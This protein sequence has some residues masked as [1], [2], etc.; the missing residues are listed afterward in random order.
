MKRCLAIFLLTSL[1]AFADTKKPAAKLKKVPPQPSAAQKNPQENAKEKP[2]EP[3]SAETFEGLKLRSIGPAMISGRIVAL[4]VDPNNRAHYYAGSASGGL[5]KTLNDGIT[6]QPVF[7]HEGSYSIGAVVLDPH[8]PNI[9]WVGTGESNSQRSVAWGDGVYRSD[10]GGKSW[11]NVGLKHSEHIGRIVIDP[12]DTNVVYVA[13]EGPLWSSG[14]DRGLYKTS[15]GGKSWQQVLKIS[16]NTG[17]GDVAMDPDN[18]D[19]LYAAAYQRQRKVWTL[20]DGGPESALYKST[21]AGKTWNKLSSGLP[22]EEMG[23]IGL[24]ISPAD[25][26]TI[27]ATIEA[28]NKAGGIFRSKDGGATWEKRNPFDSTA[29]YYAQVIADPKNVNRIYVMNFNIMDSEDGGKTLTRFPSKSKHVDNHVIWIDPNDTDYVLVGCDGGVYESYDRG[30]N[31][32]YKANLPLAQFYDITA[33]NSVP[34]YYVYGGAQD[35][36][37][38]GG[39]SRTT[40]ASGIIN[41]DWFVTQGG[42]GFRTQVDPEDPSTVYSEYQEGALTRYDRRTGETTGIQPEELQNWPIYRWNWDSP[43]IISPHSHT[44]LYFGAN[45]LFRSDD[46]GDTWRV[47]SPDLTAQIDRNQLPV[48]GKVWGPDAVAKNAS[49]SF[50]SNISALSESPVKE[51]LIVVGTDDG[52]IQ[53]SEDAGQNWRKLDKFPGV[54]DRTYVSR[55]ATSSH[56]AN[57]IYAAFENHKEGDF[58]PYLLK[59]TDL[60]KNWTS[61][62]SNLPEV[63]PVLAFAEDPTNADLLFAGTEFGAYFTVD[64]GKKW[65]QLKGDLPVIP[66][67]DFFIQARDGDLVVGTFGRGAYILDDLRPLRALKPDA[68]NAD[69]LDFSPRDTW[70]YN[71][72]EPF[73][74]RGKAHLGQSFFTGENPPFGATFTYYLKEKIKT[75]KEAREESEK[76][77]DKTGKTAAYPAAAELVKEADEPE[78]Q[79]IL[80]ITDFSGQP[81]RRITGPVGAGMHRV[82]WDLRYAEPTLAPEKP[83]EGDEDFPQGPRAPLVL[84]GEY[85]VS[86]AKQV[87]GVVTPLGQPE[88]FT[89]KI[90]AGSPTNPEDRVALIKFQQQV[91]ELYRAFNGTEETSTRLKDRVS[92][93]KRALLQAPAAATALYERA[94]KIEAANRDITRAL[95]GDEVLRRRN[96]PVPVS[97]EGRIDTILDEQR[98]SS[99]RPTATHVEQYKIASDQLAQQLQKLRS[100]IEVDLAQLEKDAEAAGTPWTPGRVP[101]WPEQ[102]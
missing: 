6:W 27:Y 45:V 14:G 33:D 55:L 63:G 94:E 76:Q 101:I 87:N 98:L 70:L 88:K 13:A 57:T 74:D 28:A 42:D 97:I 62:T 31:W 47:I 37:V 90:I 60:G 43:L 44:R 3:M 89:V 77:A 84:P 41:A 20:I 99:S 86:F 39:P 9:V 95:S 59:S 68:L 40:S 65:V 49:T 71:E 2:A 1:C 91:A 38:V 24:A 18:P 17:V 75:Q 15:D 34:F 36:N 58:K 100:L 8:D 85:T 21:D 12:R 23:R 80:T 32:L 48:M 66:V 52:L 35:N 73:G 25:S 29:M 4:A 11:K 16:D 102:K 79:I 56:N 53:I 51:G 26:N 81:V 22:K 67:R 93:L 5:W 30:Q 82:T 96:E 92:D 61:I 64:G 69:F 78:P 50:Y 10:D 72:A 19:V 54:P 46:R 7:D 83:S